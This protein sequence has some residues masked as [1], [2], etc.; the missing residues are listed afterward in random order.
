MVQ[1]NRFLYCLFYCY[2]SK[3][4]PIRR[5]ADRQGREEYSIQRILASGYPARS[6]S[7]VAWRVR[8]ETEIF[9]GISSGEAVSA[10]MAVVNIDCAVQ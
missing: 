4:R 6:G 1:G 10:F 3:A 5:S 7:A 2:F 9:S 8:G